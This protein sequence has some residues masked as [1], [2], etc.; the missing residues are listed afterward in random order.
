MISFGRLSPCTDVSP[1]SCAL[2]RMQ[3]G[4]RGATW[5]YD[6]LLV[7]AGAECSKPRAIGLWEIQKEDGETLTAKKDMVKNKALQLCSSLPLALPLS[8]QLQW[9]EDESLRR[10]TT[11]TWSFRALLDGIKQDFQRSN[12]CFRVH[13]DQR[14]TEIELFFLFRCLSPLPSPRSLLGRTPQYKKRLTCSDAKETRSKSFQDQIEAD[15]RRKPPTP[16]HRGVQNLRKRYAIL[17]G[18]PSRNRGRVRIRRRERQRGKRE[19]GR[20]EDEERQTRW[21]LRCQMMC[22]DCETTIKVTIEML[23]DLLGLWD[24]DWGDELRCLIT[25]HNCQTR[26]EVISSDVWWRVRTIKAWI[27]VLGS[28]SDDVSGLWRHG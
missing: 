5:Q 13:F 11:K 14:E 21:R 27:E 22:K 1:S 2:Q 18:Y 17:S 10:R 25:C 20:E 6:N 19:G 16:T 9:S 24:D 23:D 28:E 8:V 15:F 26:I 7:A 4:R 3:Q 12:V